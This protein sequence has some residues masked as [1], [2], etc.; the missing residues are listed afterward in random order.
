L[1]GIERRGP[2][3][4]VDLADGLGRDDT[5]VSRQVFKLERRGLIKR[6]PDPSDRRVNEAVITSEGRALTRALDAARVRIA[7]PILDRRSAKDFNALVGLMR[8]FVDNSMELP[9]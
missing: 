8:R 3:G 4:V 9:E 1:V 7:A 6:K 5:T 2:I